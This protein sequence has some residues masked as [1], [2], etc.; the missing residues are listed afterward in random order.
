MLSAIGRHEVVILNVFWL[1]EGFSV[2]IDDVV[3]DFEIFTGETDAAFHVV[4]AAVDGTINHVAKLFGIAANHL[5]TDIH[6][7]LRISI[8]A[9]FGSGYSL[10]GCRR[11]ADFVAERIVVGVLTFEGGYVACGEVEHD[12]VAALD[13]TESGKA[14]IAELRAVEVA[15]RVDYGESVLT[16]R[17]VDWRL[18][19]ARP[20]DHLV[21]PQEVAD[22]QRLFER[23]RRDFIVLTD[24]SENEIYQDERISNRI[25]PAHNGANCLVFR[26]FP[27]I[28][29]DVERNVDVEKQGIGKEHPWILEPEDPCEED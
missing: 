9:F 18:R 29:R 13:A 3:I 15:L 26:V 6:N 24:E 27:P 20:V 1:G 25:D 14:M 17:E 21:D 23:R 4:F 10:L 28:P 7:H 11:F 2:D 5:C 22:K 16:K 12:D 19:H 8:R